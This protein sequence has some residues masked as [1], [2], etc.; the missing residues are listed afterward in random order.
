M[1][2]NIEYQM[3]LDAIDRERFLEEAESMTSEIKSIIKQID[4]EN[5]PESIKKDYSMKIQLVTKKLT[6]IL[7][8]QKEIAMKAAEDDDIAPLDFSSK[9]NVS[10]HKGPGNTKASLQNENALIMSMLQKKIS[11]LRKQV[12]LGQDMQSALNTQ[13]YGAVNQCA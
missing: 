3:Q 9:A 6:T 11:T 7:D 10:P 13:W 2:E 1:N 5:A 8:S 12:E 4:D